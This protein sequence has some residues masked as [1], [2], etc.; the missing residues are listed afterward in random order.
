MLHPEWVFLQAVDIIEIPLEEL[1]YASG[2]WFKQ[3]CASNIS[4][5]GNIMQETALKIATC[6][7]VDNFTVSNVWISRCMWRHN[8]V[9]RTLAG[10]H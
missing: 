1:E 10:E 6:L 3:A 5:D 8:I 7:K 2:A 4:M 9:Y